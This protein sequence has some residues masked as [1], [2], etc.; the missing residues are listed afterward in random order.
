M[1][2]IWDLVREWLMGHEDRSVTF[3]HGGE[4]GRWF[5]ELLDEDDRAYGGAGDSQDEAIVDAWG[6]MLEAQE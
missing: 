5:C 6:V 1:K 2:S 4:G 3:K